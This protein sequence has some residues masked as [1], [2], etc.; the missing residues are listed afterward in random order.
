M[1]GFSESFL[2]AMV[3]RIYLTQLGR[4]NK[5]QVPTPNIKE[6]DVVCVRKEPTTPT[7][8]PLARVIQVHPGHDGKVRVAT[9]QTCK[10][11]YNRPVVSLVPLD[12]RSRTQNFLENCRVL[13]DG[14]SI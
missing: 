1:S 4:I 11:I 7:K 10:G 2:E 6:G 13:D 9:M 14:M 5:W 3:S 8:W 12:A